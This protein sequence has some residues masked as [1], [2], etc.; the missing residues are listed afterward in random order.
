M[1]SVSRLIPVRRWWAILVT[2]RQA[3]GRANRW[4][5]QRFARFEVANSL[6]RPENL[7]PSSFIQQHARPCSP[8]ALTLCSLAENLRRA[9][10][11]RRALSEI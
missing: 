7:G 2:Q 4:G 6:E 11:R 10:N 8:A 9:S 3:I 5:Q 1:T